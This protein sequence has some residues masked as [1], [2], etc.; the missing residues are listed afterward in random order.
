MTWK[1]YRVMNLFDDCLIR[2]ET[3]FDVKS[4]FKKK[5]DQVFQV[6]GADCEGVTSLDYA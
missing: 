3:Y 6:L 2:R 1:N 4:E 5:A